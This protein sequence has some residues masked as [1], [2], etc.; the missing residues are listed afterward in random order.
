MILSSFCLQAPLLPPLPNS[1][2]VHCGGWSRKIF[3]KSLGQLSA[4]FPLPLG[5]ISWEFFARIVLRIAAYLAHR[6]S[7]WGKQQTVGV[8]ISYQASTRCLTQMEECWPGGR[9]RHWTA[10]WHRPSQ[11]GYNL[12]NQQTISLSFKGLIGNKWWSACPTRR[13]RKR[14]IVRLQI[15][16]QSKLLT[17]IDTKSTNPVLL[18][19]SWPPA[20]VELV[21]IFLLIASFQPG[22]AGDGRAVNSSDG[23]GVPSR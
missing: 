21:L 7:L 2:A 11:Y 4:Y 5:S 23:P 17:A 19:A 18:F 15:G 8:W 13:P 10:A 3:Q 20:K 9:A 1:S 22:W 14:F 12:D 16:W 6:T